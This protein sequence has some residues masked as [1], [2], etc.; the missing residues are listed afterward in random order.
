MDTDLLLLS[1]TYFKAFSRGLR[2][3]VPHIPFCVFL[4]RNAAS[5]GMENIQ[6]H[7]KPLSV[8]FL[9]MTFNH[10]VSRLN[11]VALLAALI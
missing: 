7:T 10:S 2:I 1:L 11:L 9:G 8:S 3:P 4:R 6:K 5:F